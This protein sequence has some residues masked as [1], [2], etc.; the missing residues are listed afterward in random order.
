MP[1]GPGNA[2]GITRSMGQFARSACLSMALR[3][4]GILFRQHVHPLRGHHLLGQERHEKLNLVA[5]LLQPL[6]GAWRHTFAVEHLPQVHLASANRHNNWA[7][8]LP[9]E[10]AM[11]DRSS[12]NSGNS[13]LPPSAD[14]KEI[15]HSRALWQPPPRRRRK[16]PQD[17]RVRRAMS[18]AEL[19]LGKGSDLAELPAAD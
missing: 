8:A 6:G 11:Q 7:S 14:R 16:I 12:S 18:A 2:K 3:T 13:H 4:E 10:V 17:H 9:R 19:Q 5:H 1:G 15:K